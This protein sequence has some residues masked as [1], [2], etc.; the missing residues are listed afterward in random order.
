MEELRERVLGSAAIS[1][2]YLVMLYTEYPEHR[3][4][5]SRYARQALVGQ[6]REWRPRPTAGQYAI[7]PPWRVRA[8]WCLGPLLYLR[9]RWRA[10]AA[11]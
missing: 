1:A 6:R 9:M 10:A 8:S 5:V 3:A 11:N 7:V 2:A 4:A